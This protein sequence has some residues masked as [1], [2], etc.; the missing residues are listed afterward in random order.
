MQ[1]PI[2]CL[3]LLVGA[4]VG[5]VAIRAAIDM[6]NRI[7]SE[8]RRIIEPQANDA[9]S[10]G[11]ILTVAIQAATFLGIWLTNSAAES[12]GWGESTKAIVIVLIVMPAV[13]LVA[14]GLLRSMLKTTYGRA[15]S[16]TGLFYFVNAMIGIFVGAIALV[17]QILLGV[18]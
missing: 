13:T 3:A 9:F 18:R 2:L 14:A 17:S 6:H 4:V 10:I 8:G 7:V 16:V 5:A 15:L 1:I 11:L 12:S